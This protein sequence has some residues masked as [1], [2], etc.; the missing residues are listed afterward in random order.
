LF[1]KLF[2]RINAFVQNKKLQFVLDKRFLS[3]LKTLELLLG[4]KI[5]NQSYY[6]KAFTH[7]SYLEQYPE[8]KKSNERLE[9]FGD[10][11]LNMIVAK[12]LFDSFPFETEGFL[13]KSRASM[14]NRFRLYD[15]AA[16]L[17][18]NKFVLYNE[19]YLRGSHDGF[20]TIMADSL[21]ALIGAIYIDR[22]LK[23]AERFVHKYII[24]PFEED[25]SFIADTN[26]KGQLLEFTHAEKL[27]PPT[28]IVVKED[29]PSNNKTF[30]ID[31]YL[32]ERFVGRGVG[33]NKKMAEQEASK[34]ALRKLNNSSN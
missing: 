8:L 4:F 10:S 13:T 20:Q 21:E 26:F 14:V 3:N 34:D 22:G 16:E 33:K 25:D 2:Y 32:G 31:A 19:K 17:G 5:Y 18:L 24:E 1:G 12:F 9:F 27:L 7:R 28:Y 15:A 30:V 11:V 29:G 6:L 23:E